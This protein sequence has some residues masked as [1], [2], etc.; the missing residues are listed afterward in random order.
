[1]NKREIDFSWDFTTSNTKEYT[2][3]Y[4]SYPAMMIPQIARR[5]IEEYLPKKSSLIFDPYLGSGT[6]LVESRLNHINSIGTDLNPLARLISKSK[7]NVFNVDNII[8]DYNT[9]KKNILKYDKSI[10]VEKPIFKNIDFWFRE[11]II[12]EI[13]FLKNIIESNINKENYDFFIIPLSETIR[14]VSYTRNSEFKLYRIA[15]DKLDKHNV[16]TFAIFCKKVERN[17]KGLNDFNEKINKDNYA[18]VYDFNTCI[19]IPSNIFSD[20]VDMVL[21]SP[22]YGDSKTTVAY[23]Q[24]SRLSNQWLGINDAEKVDNSLMGGKT[25]KSDDKVIWLNSIKES[26]NNIKNI[27]EKR[28]FEVVS[29]MNDYVDSINNISNIVRKNGIVV[30]VVGNRM[31]K[32]NQIDLDLATAEIFKENGFSHIKTIIRNIPNKKMPKVNSPTNE[33][34]KLQTT[35]NSEYIV[36]LKKN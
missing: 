14:E 31:V 21:T 13:S 1:M 15:K 9:I 7:S 5:V 28:Y 3:C 23:G 29:F 6:S 12:N 8:N 4:H 19:E 17:I 16:D 35:M 18:K 2:H 25:I 32:S 27:D 11:D 33:I 24:F 30:Y 26:L 22:P 10:I 34:G 20:E 36:I